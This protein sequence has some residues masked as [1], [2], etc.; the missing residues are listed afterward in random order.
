MVV[1]NDE[2][3]CYKHVRADL[4]SLHDN[5]FKYTVCEYITVDD[6]NTDQ[7]ASCSSG[8][9]VSN[10]QNWNNRGGEVRLL[11]KVHIDDIL[12][13]QNGKIRCKRLFVIGVC[14]GEVF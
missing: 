10:A 13:V 7:T 2:V 4:S 12:A 14:S 5:D 9:H 6:A 8:L 11:C 3:Y 1:F